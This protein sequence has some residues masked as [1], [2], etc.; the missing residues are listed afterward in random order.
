MFR[1]LCHWSVQDT[2]HGQ[3]FWRIEP[4][5]PRLTQSLLINFDSTPTSIPVQN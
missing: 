3:L 4:N 1:L 5:K 2:M